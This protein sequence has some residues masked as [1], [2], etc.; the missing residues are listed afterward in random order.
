[1]ASTLYDWTPMTDRFRFLPVKLCSIVLAPLLL[2]ATFQRP[3]QGAPIEE[4]GRLRFRTLDRARF[5]FGGVLGARI[6]ANVREWLLVAPDANPGM[7]D[8]FRVR[9]RS[10]EPDL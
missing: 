2:F 10:P 8:M 7:V 1:M 4:Q 3:A 6:E 5:E 9:D